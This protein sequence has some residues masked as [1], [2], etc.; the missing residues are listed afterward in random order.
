VRRTALGSLIVTLIMF[1]GVVA[2]PSMASNRFAV[3]NVGSALTLGLV[4]ALVLIAIIVALTSVYVRR[5]ARVS[6]RP[7]EPSH[8]LALSGAF[9]A[10]S[11]S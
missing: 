6:G 3:G 2:F 7:V 4:L 11:I 1:S 9:K 5:T 10:E 8:P